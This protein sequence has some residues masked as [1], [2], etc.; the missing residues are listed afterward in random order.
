MSISLRSFVKPGG[1]RWQGRRCASGRIGVAKRALALAAIAILG[2]AVVASAQGPKVVV[3]T[4]AELQAAVANPA[5]AG[6]RIVLAPNPDGYVL[7]PSGPTQ[8]RLE[9]QTDMELEGAPGD[10]SA[11][12]IDASLLPAASYQTGGPATGALRM[13]RGHNAVRWLTLR[14]A[15][16]GQAFI[17]TD[18]TPTAPDAQTSVTVER[19]IIEGNARGI[20]FRLIGAATNGRTLT[21]YFEDNILRSNTLG[22]GQGVRIA[23]L[24]GVTGATLRAT[25]KGNSL[26]G[27]LAGLLAASNSSSGNTIAI[28]SKSN[29]YT[30]NGIGCLLVAGIATGASHADDNELT[31]DSHNDE[32]EG[33]DEPTA[34]YADAGAGLAVLGGDSAAAAAGGTNR[35]STRLDLRNARFSANPTADVVAFGA[36]GANGL[37]AGTGNDVLI[38][39]LGSTRDPFILP[40]DSI[41]AEPTNHVTVVPHRGH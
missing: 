21:G 17:E 10:S 32:F 28:D 34:V 20:D 26:E 25:I 13:G 22:M 39:L 37:V 4:A 12:V 31:F 40:T 1:C 33:N 35:N 11:V 14:N 36:R 38:T 27:N 15:T 9:L 7:S 23:I 24:Q 6:R 29:S 2:A 30:G 18:L 3:T 5:N 8:G 41:P 19:C 16:R